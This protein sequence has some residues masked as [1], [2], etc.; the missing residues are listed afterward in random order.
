MNLLKAHAAGAGEPMPPE[1]VKAGMLIRL[2]TMLEGEAGVQP[3]VVRCL[4]DLINNAIIPV[5]PADGTVGEADPLLASHIGLAMTGQWVVF[6]RGQRMSAGAALLAAGIEPVKPVGKDALA[7]ISTNALTAGSAVL[8]VRDA[9]QFVRREVVVF[10]LTLEGLNGNL[11]PFLETTASAR[12]FPDVVEAAG[13]I[14]ESLE[15]GS[16]P[17]T[18]EENPAPEKD[19]LLAGRRVEQ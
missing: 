19:K 1:T 16:L 4:V 13:L 17:N 15:G 14:R 8:A 2:K 5:V 9:A 3:D 10:G 6:F 12:P 18:S 7:I 11:S